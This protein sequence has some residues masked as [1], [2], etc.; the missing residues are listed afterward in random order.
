MTLGDN[1]PK[2][3]HALTRQTRTRNWITGLHD[4]NGTQSSE[5]KDIQH[6]A[7]SYFQKLFTTTNPQDLEE[8][9]VEVQT[10][11]TDQINDFLTASRQKVRCKRHYL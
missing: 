8:S 2:Y 4:E 11:I 3:F 9:L 5:Y 6:I 10:L 1:N 7:M